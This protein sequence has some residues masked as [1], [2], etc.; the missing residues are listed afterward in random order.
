MRCP[1]CG[2]AGFQPLTFGEQVRTQAIKLSVIVTAVFTAVFG[3][4]ELLGEPWRHYVTVGAILIAVGVSV[5]LN[6][7]E[8]V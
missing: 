6:L 1:C 5:F 4:A 3:Q 8:R 2:A 7:K